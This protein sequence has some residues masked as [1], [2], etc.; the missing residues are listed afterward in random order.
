MR[1]Q[2]VLED[3]GI[4]KCVWDVRNDADALWALYHVGLAGVTD[5]QLLENASRAGDKTYIR[6]LDKS[7]QFDLKLG[8]MEIHRWIR[9]KKEVQSLMPVNVFAAR[10]IDTKT[11]Q[12]CVNDVIH[13]PDLHPLYL[14]RIEGDWL[15]MAMEES[16]RRVAEAHSLGYKPQSPTKKLGP[17]G[18]GTEKRVVALDKMLEE[19]EERRMEDLERD[20]F[21]YDDDVGYYDYDENDDWSTNAADGAFC[22]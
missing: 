4:P 6:G 17:W 22:P 21:G 1:F 19:L 3:P 8:F 11:A 20:M 13:L 14:R 2:R 7:V 18:S 5:I 15:A 9:T 12:Y 10:P 16:A